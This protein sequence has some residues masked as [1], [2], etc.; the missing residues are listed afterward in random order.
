MPLFV[1]QHFCCVYMCRCMVFVY[2]VL[3]LM[4]VYSFVVYGYCVM[5]AFRCCNVCVVFLG[6]VLWFV[7][8]CVVVYVCV[9]SFCYICMFLRMPL[10][11]SQC[12]CC[13]SRGCCMV[14]YRVCV[15]LCVFIALLYMVIVCRY[16]IICEYS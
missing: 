9:C 3:W 6:V 16:A 4:C 2:G 14:C 13:V 7:I 8:G 10:N 11:V 12:L 1:F 15:G 5:Y